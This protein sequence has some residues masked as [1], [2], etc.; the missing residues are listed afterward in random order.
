[1]KKFTEPEVRILPLVVQDEVTSGLEGYGLD[2][3]KY[4]SGI[5]LPAEEL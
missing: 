5:R 3:E 4:S 1:M 2:D